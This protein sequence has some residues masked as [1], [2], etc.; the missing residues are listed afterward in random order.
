MKRRGILKGLRLHHGQEGGGSGTGA[1]RC[2][3]WTRRRAGVR[4]GRGKVEEAA[5]SRRSKAG[6]CADGGDGESSG[7][8]HKKLN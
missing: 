4:I 7:G 1:G 2:Q 6:C 3:R 5:R 8:K